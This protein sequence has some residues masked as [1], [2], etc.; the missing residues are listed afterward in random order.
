[1]G[2]YLTGLG[3]SRKKSI[4]LEIFFGR[5]ENMKGNEEPDQAMAAQAQNLAYV[6]RLHFS[7]PAGEELAG[8]FCELTEE[9]MGRAFFTNS[10]SPFSLG[11]L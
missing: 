11:R 9:P 4:S 1:L 3:L 10:G 6:Y 8:R 7:S 2:D 5:G